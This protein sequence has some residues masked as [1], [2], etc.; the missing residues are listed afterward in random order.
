M[1]KH[2]KIHK[3]TGS[4]LLRQ[5]HLAAAA[6]GKDI[7]GFSPNDFGLHSAHSGVAMAMYLAGVPVYTIML[8]EHRS[9]DAF[10]CYIHK[11]VK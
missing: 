1:D 3:I 9:S 5:I 7:L 4:Q 8:L 10:L 2:N 11:G 6:I